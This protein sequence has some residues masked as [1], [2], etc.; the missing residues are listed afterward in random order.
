[1][2]TLNGFHLEF[3]PAKCESP[4]FTYGNREYEY[5]FTSK[6]IALSGRWEPAISKLFLD[7]GSNIL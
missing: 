5:I 7:R 4:W 3:S 2:M 6:Q 1:M